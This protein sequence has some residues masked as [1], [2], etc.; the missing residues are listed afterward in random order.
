MKY[1][2]ACVCTSQIVLKI[3]NYY[4]SNAG[5]DKVVSLAVQAVTLSAIA[6]S[7]VHLLGAA[8]VLLPSFVVLPRNGSE[9]D[10]S[11]FEWAPRRQQE[12]RPV[13]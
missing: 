12:P 9:W 5:N 3:L 11:H 10:R 6:T 1:I 8:K 7:A 13:D 4:V 2:N